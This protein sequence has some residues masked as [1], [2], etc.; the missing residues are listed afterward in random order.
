MSTKNIAHLDT[1]KKKHNSMT[2][3]LYL[4]SLREADEIS[5]ASFAKKLKISKSSLSDIEKGRRLLSPK[6]AIRFS[7]IL[8][9]SDET[10]IRL[11][12]QD[13][14]RQSQKTHKKS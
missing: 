1:F 2:L 11:L 14:L 4:R 13:V 12:L 8:N 3:G 5:Q 6:K 9:L 7:R 10:L